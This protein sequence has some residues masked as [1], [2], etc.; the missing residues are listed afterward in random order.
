MKAKC[1]KYIAAIKYSEKYERKIILEIVIFLKNNL[2]S[3]VLMPKKNI[4]NIK[5]ST[6]SWYSEAGKP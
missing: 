6:Y 3:S 2:C 1:L 4:I 5:G